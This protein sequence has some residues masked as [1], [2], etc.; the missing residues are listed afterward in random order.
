[1]QNMKPVQ[2]LCIGLILYT[3]HTM[4]IVHVLTVSLLFQNVGY[5]GIFNVLSSKPVLNKVCCFIT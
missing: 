1:M 3:F 4:S 2:K 5:A